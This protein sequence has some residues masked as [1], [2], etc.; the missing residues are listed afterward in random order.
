M[1]YTEGK[2][3]GGPLASDVSRGFVTREEGGTHPLAERG[4]TVRFPTPVDAAEEETAEARAGNAGGKEGQ[5]SGQ[6]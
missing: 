3:R 4:E 2:L 6:R 5:R 1:S